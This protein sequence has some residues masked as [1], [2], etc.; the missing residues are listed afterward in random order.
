MKAHPKMAFQTPNISL[1]A[2][3]MFFSFVYS[4]LWAAHAPSV[5]PAKRL[6][7]KWF[8]MQRM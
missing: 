6:S 4:V 3:C 2:I 1:N 7:I 5:D 8:Q